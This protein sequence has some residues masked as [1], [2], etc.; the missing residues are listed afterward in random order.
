[1]RNGE[2]LLAAEQAGCEALLTT[3]TNLRY[4]QNLASRQIAIV[5]LRKTRWPRI[6]QQLPRVLDAIARCTR[7]AYLEVEFD[8]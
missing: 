2:L 8:P 7:G 3:D 1:M 6:R 5:V 4:Q